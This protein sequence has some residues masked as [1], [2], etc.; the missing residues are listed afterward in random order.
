ML[1][2]EQR[3]MTS[4]DVQKTH[5]VLAERLRAFEQEH[6][7]IAE[8]MRVMGLSLPEYLRALAAL[9]NVPSVSSNASS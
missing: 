1:S 3:K 4:P 9:R 6:P 2:R 5:A 7:E 8:A